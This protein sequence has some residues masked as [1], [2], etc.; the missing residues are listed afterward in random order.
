MTTGKIRIISTTPGF[1]RGGVS[2]PADKTY[3]ANHFTEKQLDAFRADPVLTVL[4]GDLPSDGAEDVDALKAELARAL[5]DRD[6]AVQKLHADAAA[7]SDRM[8]EAKADLAE[9]DEKFKAA[10]KD[11]ADKADEIAALKKA[12]AEKKTGSK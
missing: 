3:P 4:D 10:V 5:A 6:A 11:A 8:K 12:A 1:R 9:M 7:Y 2:H